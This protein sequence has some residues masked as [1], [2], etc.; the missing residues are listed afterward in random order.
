MCC[1]SF[2]LVS[3]HDPSS[4]LEWHLFCLC[5]VISGAGVLLGDLRVSPLG[6]QHWSCVLFC[7]VSE[8]LIGL[9]GV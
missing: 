4:F 3:P 6:P 9:Y 2:P 8:N 5:E 7:G 1:A